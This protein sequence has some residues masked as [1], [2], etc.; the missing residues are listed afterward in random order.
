[1]IMGI[2]NIA[3]LFLLIHI[4]YDD[5][6]KEN[7]SGLKS[8]L[9]FRRHSLIFLNVSSIIKKIDSIKKVHFWPKIISESS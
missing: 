4:L 6:S 5:L 9:K 2:L 1:M 7:V 3:T 8:L